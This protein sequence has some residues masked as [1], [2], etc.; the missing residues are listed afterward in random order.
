M[1]RVLVVSPSFH[2]Y[3]TAISRAFESLGYDVEEFCYDLVKSPRE[4]AWN[5]LRHELPGKLRGAESLMS[6]ETITQRAIQVLRETKPD[7]V[8]VIRGD[9]F[10]ES[11]W[12]EAHAGSRPVLVWMYDEMRRTAFDQSMVSQ[13]AKIATYSSLDTEALQ[14]CGIDAT[15]VPLAY[16]SLGSI[17]NNIPAAGVISFIGAPFEKRTYALQLLASEGLP[18][19]AWGRG[20]SDHPV[21]RARTWR[22]QRSGIPNGRDVAGS[23]ALGIMRHSAAT[24][25]IHGDQDGFTMRT[26]EACGVGAIQ[27]IDRSEVSRYYEPGRE[28]LVFENDEE[29]I[30]HARRVL[31]RPSDFTAMRAYA[32]DRTLAEHTLIHRAQVLE[33]LW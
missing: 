18:I 33:T 25:N 30:E 6:A 21:D 8:L 3:S 17:T 27:L 4:K 28:L 29:L 16:D 23:D 26:F 7:L 5:K 32:Q 19:Q 13:Y 12:E 15:H 10:L 1:K 24:L 31:A 2:G 9:I 22:L 14:A 11:F 20:W